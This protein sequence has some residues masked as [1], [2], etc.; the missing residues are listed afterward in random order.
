M[1]KRP[2]T[3]SK[4]ARVRER[5]SM[6]ELVCFRF[7]SQINLARLTATIQ[8]F[9]LNTRAGE[10]DEEKLVITFLRR[11]FIFITHKEATWKVTAVAAFWRDW[12]RTWAAVHHAYGTETVG[13]RMVYAKYNIRQN[14]YQ[15]NDFQ[16]NP[17]NCR[18]HDLSYF[19]VQNCDE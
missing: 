1:C 13:I 8:F 11:I 5:E 18:A 7:R 12:E 10:R 14:S 17:C 3:V 19:P 4:C 15:F 2:W 16:S 6:Y 9:H